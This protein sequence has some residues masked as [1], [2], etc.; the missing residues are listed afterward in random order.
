MKYFLFFYINFI[1]YIFRKN[2]KNE[3]KIRIIFSSIFREY[4]LLIKY[5]LN[6]K[7][8]FASNFILII[9]FVF[10]EFILLFLLKKIFKIH[11]KKYFKYFKIII[12]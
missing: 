2:N 3:I 1:Y 6:I 12:K 8:F 5:S 10:F 9:S 4:I 7:L 11:S